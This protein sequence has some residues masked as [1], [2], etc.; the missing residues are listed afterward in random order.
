ML[1]LKSK[2]VLGFLFILICIM[3]INPFKQKTFTKTF[4]GTGYIFVLLF[5]IS[6][7]YEIIDWTNFSTVISTNIIDFIGST[8]LSGILLVIV[9]FLSIIIISIFI[10]GTVAKWNLIAPIYVPLSRLVR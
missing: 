2:K 3:F 6:I 10:P 8:N 9:A 5:F 1:E 7:L 4:E